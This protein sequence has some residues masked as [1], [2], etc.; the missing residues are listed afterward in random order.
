MTD[1]HHTTE[2]P[3]AL[4]DNAKR[5]LVQ[6]SEDL[7]RDVYDLIRTSVEEAALEYFRGRNDDPAI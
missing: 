6:I 4:D 1:L 3:I 7:G 5:R 2:W